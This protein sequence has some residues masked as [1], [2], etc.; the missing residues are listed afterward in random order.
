[1]KILKKRII[2]RKTIKITI[3]LLMSKF[4]LS[5]FQF[6]SNVT[7]FLNEQLLLKSIILFD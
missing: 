2:L 1:M 7:F 6:L 5:I 4:I 3:Q